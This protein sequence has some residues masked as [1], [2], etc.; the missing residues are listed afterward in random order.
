MVVSAA[1]S[2]QATVAAKAKAE[3]GDTGAGVS[4]ALNIAGN[5]AT[6]ALVEGTLTGGQDVTLSATGSHKLDTL[7]EGGGKA[8][9]AGGTGIGGALALTVAVNNDTEARVGADLTGLEIGGALSVTADHHGVASTR[10]DGK[11]V[12]DEA[13]VG[14]ALALSFVDDSA[15]ARLDRDVTAGGAVSIA[16]RGDGSSE[17]KGVASAAGA[18]TSKEKNADGTTKSA[19]DQ[20]KSA[21]GLAKTQSGDSDLKI[22]K[23][24][25][26]DDGDTGTE[27]DGAVSVGAALG[28]NVAWSAAQ[29]SIGD[30]TITAGKA[31]TLR[32]E[33]NMDAI[34]IG[35]G[36]AASN[37]DD[38]T[39]VGIG[40]AINVAFMDNSATVGSGATID[41]EGFKADR[42]AHV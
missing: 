13:A 10:A 28:L 41:A 31:V 19:E 15:S 22:G 4:I 3:S 26:T 27:E 9:A 38:A 20:A 34:A 39:A 2:T 37:K 1:N 35:D 17:A 25:S 18:D 8:G 14:V 29:A 30:V 36:S 11:A 42:K 33:N 40:I 24:A 32:S 6:R 23:T 7:A 21:T 16:A 5:N 12:G